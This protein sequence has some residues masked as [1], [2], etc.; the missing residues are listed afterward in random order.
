LVAAGII[1]MYFS[2]PGL[3]VIHQEFGVG[4]ATASLSLSVTIRLNV[5]WEAGIIFLAGSHCR[6]LGSGR[7]S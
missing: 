7:P 3:P 2:Q 5:A 1:N 6:S 4:A